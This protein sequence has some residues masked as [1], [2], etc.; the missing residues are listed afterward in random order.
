ML[1]EDD[2]ALLDLKNKIVDIWVAVLVQNK[3]TKTA[4]YCL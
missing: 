3:R 4:L 2:I 1:R